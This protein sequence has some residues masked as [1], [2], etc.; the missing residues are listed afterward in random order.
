MKVLPTSNAILAMIF[1][2][3]LAPPPLVRNNRK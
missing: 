2:I 3:D 1:T